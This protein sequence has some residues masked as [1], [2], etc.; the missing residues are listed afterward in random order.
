VFTVYLCIDTTPGATIEST[1]DPY[2]FPTA[3][4]ARYT[5]IHTFSSANFGSTP[6]NCTP[7]L[8]TF[9]RNASGTKNVYA[10]WFKADIN[11][12]FY[13]GVRFF[14]PYKFNGDF[15][16]IKLWGWK[17]PV[18]SSYKCGYAFICDAPS[19]P[20][21]FDVP[22]YDDSDLT[23]KVI[24]GGYDPAFVTA[25]APSSP[26]WRDYSTTGGTPNLASSTWS[27]QTVTISS[28]PATVYRTATGCGRFTL[29]CGASK[30]HRLIRVSFTSFDPTSSSF[31]SK[32]INHN[33]FRTN[34]PASLAFI[35][36]MADANGRVV[37]Y[38]F[39][40][41]GSSVAGG[42]IAAN[43]QDLSDTLLNTGT[44]VGATAILQGNNRLGGTKVSL[45]AGTK[46]RIRVRGRGGHHFVG[47]GKE[48]LGNYIFKA[49]LGVN[50]VQSSYMSVA[51]DDGTSKAVASAIRLLWDS[52]TIN[53]QYYGKLIAY[54]WYM[55]GTGK[56]LLPAN[57]Y[58]SKNW[59]IGT[60]STAN[61]GAS[62][63]VIPGT[64]SI[65]N[66]QYNILDVEYTADETR[67]YY[68]VCSTLGGIQAVYGMVTV[69]P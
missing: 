15:K 16:S 59:S 52:T 64:V 8:Y 32:E 65:E 42:G 57:R 54:N 11:S 9:T 5:V 3:I 21:P 19:E 28:F 27:D 25:D 24:P 44:A 37:F 49:S 13:P 61:G 7:E 68:I 34:S 38:D 22:Y 47:F 39:S 45:V 62:W 17:V 58:M 33:E 60:W 48:I 50:S 1:D 26:Y 14:Q 55:D 69:V 20:L 18:A 40:R 43:V 10:I 36:M 53:P 63:G 56:A 67:D 35:D 30:A 6:N 31:A 2:T 51:N 46:Y 29:E 66:A 41:W 4:P 23:W 12:F